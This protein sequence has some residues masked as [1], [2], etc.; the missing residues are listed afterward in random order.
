M[1]F[2]LVAEYTQRFFARGRAA[3]LMSVCSLKMAVQSL[4]PL[5]L[6]L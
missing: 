5:F 4:A 2:R 3:A 6:A 1:G